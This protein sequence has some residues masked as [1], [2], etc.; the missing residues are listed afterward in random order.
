ML[1]RGSLCGRRDEDEVYAAV[2]DSRGTSDLP[3][4]CGILTAASFAMAP[5]ADTLRLWLRVDVAAASLREPKLGRA[6]GIAH[7]VAGFDGVLDLSPGRT[8]LIGL[9]EP[10]PGRS[11]VIVL[12]WER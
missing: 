8:R 12:R 2:L 1:R 9:G 11:L 5:Q 6:G 3:E 4:H 7:Q 10:A